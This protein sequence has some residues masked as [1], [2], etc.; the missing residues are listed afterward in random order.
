MPITPVATP[1]LRSQR[2]VDATAFFLAD[3]EGGLGP[4]LAIYLTTLQAWPASRVGIAMAA[5]VAGTLV[6]QIP[7]GALIDRARHKRAAVVAAATVVGLCS[8]AMVG[9]P[10]FPVIIAAQTLLGAAAALLPP[11]LAG[12]SLGLVGA[13]QLARR[14]GRNEAFNHAGNVVAAL[15][16]GVAGTYLGYDAIFYLVA[17]MAAASALAVMLV[18]EREID[19]SRARAADPASHEVRLL[20]W[21]ADRRVATFG[22][23]VFLFHFANAA[24]LPLV[25]QKVSHSQ[26]RDAAALM[27]ACIVAAQVVMVPVAIAAARFAD[28]WGRKPV[29]LL[30]FAVLPVRALLYTLSVHAV[31]L[32]AVQ[33]LDGIGA[34]IYGVVGVLVA[35]DLSRGSG[36]FNLTLGMMATAAG[37]GA[38]SSNLLTGF[39]VQAAGFDRGFLFLAAI[40]LVGLT[41]FALTVAETRQPAPAAVRP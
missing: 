16:A 26:P 13:Q 30:A 18:R 41:W 23:S 21:L 3:V 19:H 37:L 10:Q 6:A 17:G 5:V 39:V 15:L 2:A 36:R 35:S 4:Y 9:V 32:V 33:L 27:S 24:M 7:A 28:R 12:I 29:F 22:L 40:A 25:G 31:F 20:S 8:I 11:A 14:A 34:G 1:S 38:A